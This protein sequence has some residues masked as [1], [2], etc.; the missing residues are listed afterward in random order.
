MQEQSVIKTN[1]KRRIYAI[2]SSPSKAYSHDVHAVS[3]HFLPTILSYPVDRAMPFCTL[4]SHS[5]WTII[6]V[7]D[8]PPPP[9]IPSYAQTPYMKKSNRR[10]CFFLLQRPFWSVFCF[11]LMECHKNML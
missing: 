8:V 9:S 6:K 1:V 3:T 11:C 4:P 10:A 7:R 2:F 5:P